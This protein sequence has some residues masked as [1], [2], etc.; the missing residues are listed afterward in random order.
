MSSSI[1]MMV[2]MSLELAV[3]LFGRDA[4]GELSVGGLDRIDRSLFLT[5]WVPSS[6]GGWIGWIEWVPSGACRIHSE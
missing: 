4:K 5:E 1:S 3:D 6:V 2:H